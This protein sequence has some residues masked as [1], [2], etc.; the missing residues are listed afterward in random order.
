MSV[1][2]TFLEVEILVAGEPVF[3]LTDVAD[4]LSTKPVPVRCQPIMD[5]TFAGL[6]VFVNLRRD[7]HPIIPTPDVSLII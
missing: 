4:F 5:S 2:D 7:N 1:K 6:G 3:A